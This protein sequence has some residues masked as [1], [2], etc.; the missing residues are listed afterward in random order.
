MTGIEHERNRASISGGIHHFR[1]GSPIAIIGDEKRILR[2]Q[3]LLCRQREFAA[4]MA[5]EI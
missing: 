3:I 4:R 2:A 1:A 5:I